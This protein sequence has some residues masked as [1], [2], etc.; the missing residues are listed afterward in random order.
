LEGNPVKLL[1][2]VAFA[3]FPLAAPAQTLDSSL[4]A[5]LCQDDYFEDTAG[6]CSAISAGEVLTIEAVLV[7]YGAV[8]TQGTDDEIAHVFF[9]DPEETPVGSIDSRSESPTAEHAILTDDG[10]DAEPALKEETIASKI[11]TPVPQ[12][13]I[14]TEDADDIATTGPSAER[15]PA[16]AAAP[17]DDNP[18][19]KWTSVQ[20]P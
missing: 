15:S 20:R 10:L 11:A 5:A 17:V 6:E 13:E 1:Y 3:M 7:K 16:V 14:T 18:T 4:Q 19:V 8:V 9:E 12:L 2:A